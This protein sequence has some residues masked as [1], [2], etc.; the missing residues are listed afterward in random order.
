MKLYSLEQLN[1]ERMFADKAVCREGFVFATCPNSTDVPVY[2][3]KFNDEFQRFFND[4]INCEED[5]RDCGQS[6][7]E[8]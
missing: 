2:S 7:S 8:G 4:Q 6:D 1:G 3:I 5:I